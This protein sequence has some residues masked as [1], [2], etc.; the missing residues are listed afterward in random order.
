MSIP[1]SNIV[2]INPGVVA[3]GGNPLSL[4]GLFLTENTS[5][6]TNT[7]L[8]FPTALAVSKYFGPS[9]GEYLQSQ[10]YF[11]GYTNGS[12]IPSAMLFAAFNLAAR[13]AFLTSGSL[14]GL[15]LTQLQTFDGT[16]ILTINGTLETSSTINL[17]GA[18]S[19][20]NA[21]TLI[22]AG[23]SG[24]V[25]TVTYN[26]VTN[27]FVFTSPTTGTAS[28]ITFATGTIA[29]DLGLTSATGAYLSQGDTADTPATALNSAIAVSQN[30]ISIV[31]LWEPTVTDKTNFAIWSN[32]QNNRYLYIAWDTD[33]QAI[34]QNATEPFGAIAKLAGYNGVAAISGS[35]A[36]IATLIAAGSVPAGTTL[37][38]ATL[39]VASFV[40][41]TIASINFAQTN[42]NITLAF[43]NQSGLSPTCTSTPTDKTLIANGY[44]FY[45]QYATAN[46]QFTFLNNGNMPGEFGWINDFVN[47]VY[48]NSQ[49]QLDDMTL[50]TNVG[51]VPYD[52]TGYALLRQSKQGTIN[53][54][55]NYG[56]IQTGVV[57][58]TE[59]VAAVNQAA[60]VNAASVI[61]TNGY[62]LQI[63]DPGATV[64]AARGT[65]IQN[66][67]Y[68][69]GGS[70]Q[71]LVLSSLEVQ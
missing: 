59:Q 68:T 13:A 62:Y 3:A 50:L 43:R 45:G 4:N 10:I 34:V 6:P 21:A 1:A 32:G 37:A 55:L 57:L 67:W 19:F 14:A 38:T 25:P 23:F 71:Q 33:A 48:M 17:A 47:Q 31:T 69:S 24:T 16:L 35:A 61:Q 2:T 28:T 5:M 56:G 60:G 15:T 42:G 9:S 44:S 49:F 8:S 41:G 66:L 53:A 64:R 36:D 27:T 12:L 65:P 51:Q 40:A 20:S 22:Q 18:T 11:G 52:P 7:V 46:Q 58:S 54:M 70:V 30:F 39:A 63:L 29:T 26:A